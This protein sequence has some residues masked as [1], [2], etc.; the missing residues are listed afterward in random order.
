M[1]VLL[2]ASAAAVAGVRWR[3]SASAHR[4]PVLAAGP[5]LPILACEP[6]DFRLQRSAAAP[7]RAPATALRR[8]QCA[9]G[10]RTA[11]PPAFPRARARAPNGG[12]KRLGGDSCAL[13]STSLCMP[14]VAPARTAALFIR[15]LIQCCAR[16]PR[17]PR[18]RTPP[19]H[20]LPAALPFA[21][22]SRA[23]NPQSAVIDADSHPDS[24]TTAH[25]I[26]DHRPSP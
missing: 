7:A 18:L 25:R 20:S 2:H 6:F 13:K 5:W 11:E 3:V 4:R 17:N 15:G 1:S 10:P 9:A 24:T 16:C 22:K 8:R 23:S 19:K 26:L 14:R 12:C 21:F